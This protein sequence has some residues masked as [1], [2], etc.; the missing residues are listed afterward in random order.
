M[1]QTTFPGKTTT[2]TT[3]TTKTT[4]TTTTKT[5]DTDNHSFP[6]Q[7]LKPLGR[8]RGVGSTGGSVCNSQL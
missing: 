7:K 3:K 8:S 2:T 1:G 6:E 4:T 5:V